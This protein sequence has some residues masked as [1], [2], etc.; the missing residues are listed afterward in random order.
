[1]SNERVHFRLLKM[2]CCQHLFC[3]VNSRLP[4]YCPNCGQ[5]VYPQIK[6]C[7]VISDENA[8]LNYDENKQP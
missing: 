7:A 6:H 8:W 4:S 1:M 5:H 2:P 3:N